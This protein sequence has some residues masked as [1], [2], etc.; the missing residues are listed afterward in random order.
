MFYINT[1]LKNHFY[2]YEISKDDGGQNSRWM[3]AWKKLKEPR[4]LNFVL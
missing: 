2:N 3:V 1:V 4:I